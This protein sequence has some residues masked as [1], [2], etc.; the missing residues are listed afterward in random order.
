MVTTAIVVLLVLW[1]L[2]VTSVAA[3]FGGT[4]CLAP[5]ATPG[6]GADIRRWD[7]GA[8]PLPWVAPPFGAGARH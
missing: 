8:A 7:D 5:D 3:A 1:G 2:S 4:T 6:R